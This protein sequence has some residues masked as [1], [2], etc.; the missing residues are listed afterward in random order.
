MGSRQGD[1]LEVCGEHLSTRGCGEL[2]VDRRQRGFWRPS[3]GP[4]A[5]GTQW[6]QVGPFWDHE[7]RS[8]SPAPEVGGE[9]VVVTFHEWE[10][11]SGV[12]GAC[13]VPQ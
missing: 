12:G 3:G 9:A 2:H 4:P 10:T 13:A 5:W 6:E 11:G 1:Y 7:T 8:G